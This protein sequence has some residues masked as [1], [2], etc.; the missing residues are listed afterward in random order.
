LNQLNKQCDLSAIKETDLHKKAQAVLSNSKKIN[1]ESYIKPEDIC[2]GNQ[3]LNVIFTAAIFNECHGLDPVTEEEAYEAAKLLEDDDEGSREERS[4]RLWMNSLNISDVYFNNLYEDCK[5]GCLLLKVIDKVS[6]GSVNW[7][8][9][10]DN[11][12]NKFK[13]CANCNVA[14]DSMKKAGF[15]APGIGGGDVHNGNK[16]L[17]LALIWQ[18]MRSHSLQIIGNKTEEEMVTWGNSISGSTVTSLKDKSL[19]NSL[20]FIKIM[21]GIEPRAVNWDLVNQEENLTDEQIENNAKYAISISRK[22][23]ATVFLVWED[24]RDLKIKMLTTFLA[25]ILDVYNLEFA[26]KNEKKKIKEE[27]ENQ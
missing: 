24:I 9:V 7:K 26:L 23:G 12:N 20:W 6:P 4:F 19:K 15:K 3:K 13:K 25:A 22:L 2:K 11:P 17:V 16:K 5:D 1:V 8:Q 21:S 27:E 18:L 10:E 14:V